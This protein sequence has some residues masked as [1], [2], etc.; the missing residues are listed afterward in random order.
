MTHPQPPGFLALPAGGTGPAVLVLHAWWGLNDTMKSFC[1]RL[2]AEG[3]VVFAPDLYH[4][5][6][7]VT[8]EE[9]EALRN[10]LE[11]EQARVEQARAEIAAAVDFLAGRARSGPGLG[12]IGFSLGAYYA[13]GLSVD[14][15]DRVRAVVVF[16][17]TRA[18]DYRRSKASY[19]GH[20][21][22]NDEF[23][24]TAE[25]EGLESALRA[26][27]RPVTLHHYEGTGH[28]FFEPDRSDAYRHDAAQSAWERTISFLR[29]TM[30]AYRR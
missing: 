4:G 21:A 26:A 30:A 29:E 6:V 27:G 13:L 23:E 10:M 15:P 8:I 1:D 11:G 3:F 5:K 19:L 24:P 22:E 16:Y 12:V 7:A 17:G 28:W 20:F 9:A 25:V 14:D 2:A 18:E